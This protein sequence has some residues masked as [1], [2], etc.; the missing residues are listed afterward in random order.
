MFGNII[1]KSVGVTF[2]LLFAYDVN[3]IDILKL[4]ILQFVL[5]IYKY[6]GKLL[7][8]SLLFDAI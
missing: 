7:I 5:C 2:F 8:F 4:F 1:A 6:F 3:V